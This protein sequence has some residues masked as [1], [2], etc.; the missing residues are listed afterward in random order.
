MRIFM[1]LFLSI[2][3]PMEKTPTGVP[4]GVFCLIEIVGDELDQAII[5]V[6]SRLG[7]ELTQ[8]Y[9]AILETA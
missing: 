2:L 3:T 6:G 9:D 7:V 8:G 5:Q 1:V 4:V